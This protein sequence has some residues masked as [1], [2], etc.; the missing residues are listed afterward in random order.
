[1][2]FP[3]REIPAREPHPHVG[4]WT[5]DDDGSARPQNPVSNGNLLMADYI[6]FVNN[7]GDA[8]P[9]R[10]YFADS[11]CVRVL[12]ESIERIVPAL[13]DEMPLWVDATVDAY[14][15][16]LSTACPMDIG[17]EPPEAVETQWPLDEEGIKQDE[18]KYEMWRR[19]YSLFGRFTGYRILTDPKYW[20][21]E[22]R[23][24]LNAF[25]A[26]CLDACVEYRPI[27]ITVP[28]L[29]IPPG[30]SR[31]KINRMLA[32]AAGRWKSRTRPDAKLILP[33]VF[34]SSAILRRKPQRDDK[35]ETALQ[36]YSLA[37]AD[38]MWVVDMT[39][40]DQNLSD[41]FL[42]R[43]SSL[44]AFHYG[45]R[46]RL[47][48]DAPV[49]AGPYWGMN[50]VLWVRR[51]CRHPALGIG[52]SYTYYTPMSP[53]QKGRPKLAIPPLRRI[54][55]ASPELQAWLEEVLADLSPDDSMYPSLKGLHDQLPLLANKDV[56]KDQLASS[57]KDWIDSITA[58]VPNERALRLYE[59]LSRAYVLGRRLPRM[60]KGVLSGDG[61]AGVREPGKVAE[62]LMLMSL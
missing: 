46:E 49:V 19:W 58:T 9:A 51:L 60:P 34:T 53:I 48:S 12:L 57:Y 36:C 13:P 62:Q 23:D 55:V 38:G 41:N 56:A 29:P 14:D 6:P 35:L 33:V 37:L 21:K 28:Q 7:E 30:G 5:A 4:D 16:I 52:T 31:N 27:W 45:L 44:L 8:T 11:H 40:S 54:A 61:S 50:L 39:L 32:E 15:C 1:V 18:W 59:D 10:K 43:Y 42:D 25:V 20:V 47:G 17:N 26:E 2:L 3:D 22:Y 24:E